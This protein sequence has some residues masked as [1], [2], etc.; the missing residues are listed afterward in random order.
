MLLNQS[1]S[2]RVAGEHNVEL[3]WRG[4]G[5][6]DDEDNVA[7]DAVD[8]DDDDDDDEVDDVG[9]GDGDVAGDGDSDGEGD[10]DGSGEDDADYN[11][12]DDHTQ[13]H[14]HIKPQ[15]VAK[16]V[17]TFCSPRA[18]V[19]RALGGQNVQTL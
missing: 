1:K 2:K 16:L 17:F 4:G 14:T 5:G 19:E 7:Y 11:A 6:G 10:G 12:D 9:Y 3:M 18:L 13:L 8:D 15:I